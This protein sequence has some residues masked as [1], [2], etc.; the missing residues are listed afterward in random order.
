MRASRSRESSGSSCM[1]L[2]PRRL[3]AA[4]VS[5]EM[6]GA[7]LT[8][9]G[10]DAADAIVLRRTHI[11]VLQVTANGAVNTFALSA[12][13]SMS[14]TCGGGNDLVDGDY[15]GSQIVISESIPT[16]IDGGDGDDVL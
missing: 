12:I 16:T 5:V 13:N 15:L 3:R 1:L 9:R 6:V 4:A 2:E 10:T 7:T 11:D 14:I 8:I